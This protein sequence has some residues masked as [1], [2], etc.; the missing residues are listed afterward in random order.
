L[1]V[2]LARL[3]RA[4]PWD[5]LLV[6]ADARGHLPMLSQSLARALPRALPEAL[7]EAVHWD[8]PLG[9]LTPQQQVLLS[10]PRRA[11]FEAA[12]ALV[13]WAR[14]GILI[15]DAPTHGSA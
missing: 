2:N 10:D 5:E 12:Q 8:A 7:R 9:V 11:G 14:G 3:M 6:L 15:S 13:H 1:G 4:G